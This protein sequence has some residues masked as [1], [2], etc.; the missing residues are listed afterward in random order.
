MMQEK[1]G[2]LPSEPNAGECGGVTL[3]VVRLPDGTRPARRFHQTD[4][5]R[6]LFGFVDAKVCALAQPVLSS[7]DAQENVM[8]A[9]AERR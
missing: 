8:V 4:L 1:E 6:L 5:L 2:S 3:C 9:R 7:L